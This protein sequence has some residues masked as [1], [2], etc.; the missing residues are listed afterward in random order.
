MGSIVYMIQCEKCFLVPGLCEQFRCDITQYQKL[1]GAGYG[2]LP[3]LKATLVPWETVAIDLVGPCII[4]VKDQDIQFNA[5]TYID[6]VTNL[7]EQQR[8]L[9]KT[10]FHVGEMFE[11]IWVS[12]YPRPN[13]CIHDL[14]G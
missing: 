11:N 12:R 2:K 4:K 8:L 9:N 3:A 6:P 10:A 1:F 14:G 7:V 5:L 13:K